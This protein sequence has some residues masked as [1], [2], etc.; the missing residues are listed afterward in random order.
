MKI[1]QAL[2]LLL[3]VLIALPQ[4]A[5]A[6]KRERKGKK[7]VMLELTAY[8]PDAM[9]ARP[10][11]ERTLK[12]TATVPQQHARHGKI[13]TH[14]REGIDVSHYQGNIDWETVGKEAKIAYAYLKAT[15]GA[16]LVDDTYA[17]NLR[18]ARK[19]G[20]SV[21]SYHFYRPNV[22]VEEQFLNLTA[23]VRAEEQDIV[24]MID[25]EVRGSVS[26][27]KFIADLRSFIERVA[28]HYGR[29]PLLYTYHNFYNKHF[30]GEFPGY[31]WMIARYRPDEP[32]LNDGTDYIMWQYSSTGRVPGIRGNC[33][34]SCLMDGFH[35]SALQM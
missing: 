31:Q 25:I 12:E 8:A 29:K 18:E 35:L 6:R 7:N 10:Q 1:P 26:E 28:R 22:G 5:E 21:G 4:A 15:E 27:E 30:Q 17:R 2:P 33:D 34:R 20:I 11:R 14:Y 19:A 32:T 16:Q 23:T 3:A 13:N 24:P 9:A